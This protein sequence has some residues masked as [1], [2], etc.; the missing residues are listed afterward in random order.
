MTPLERQKMNDLEQRVRDLEQVT[1]PSFVAELVRRAGGI[2]VSLTD[3]ASTTGTSETVRN[4]ADSGGEAVAGTYD[5]VLT[6]T[7]LQG[8]TYRVGYYS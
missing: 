6:L 8:N 5:G 7:D 1:N 4:A 3:G 2:S